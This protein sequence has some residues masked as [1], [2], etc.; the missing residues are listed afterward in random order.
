MPEQ[1]PAD[2]QPR[3]DASPLAS[4]DLFPARHLGP[5]RDE[6]RAMIVA[7]VRQLRDDHGLDGVILGGTELPLLLGA[8]VIEGLPALDTT[9]LHVEAI[10]RRLRVG[11]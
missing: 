6:T 5:R 3:T 2:P 11:A 7:L 10:V 8:P 9:A 1:Q 4:S